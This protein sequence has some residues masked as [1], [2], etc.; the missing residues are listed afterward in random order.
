MDI[1]TS[2]RDTKELNKLVKTMLELAIED[3]KKQGV[4][5]LIVETYRPQDR[6]NYLYCQG[7][8]I[9]ECVTKGINKAFATKHCNIKVS[10]VTWTLSSI[11]KNRK[12]V[13]VV[14][15]R[16]IDG[17]M[18]AIWNAKYKETIIIINTMKKYGFEA[19]V[20]W[21]TTPDSPHFQVDGN[22][23]NVFDI[24][25][26]TKFVTIAIQT[27]LNRKINANLTVDG[28]WK[29]KTDDAV[30]KFRKAMKYKNHSGIIGAGAFK[31]LMR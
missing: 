23:T 10:K 8:T 20:D 24:S 2:S 5:P 14:P 26:N 31:E 12:A 21:K 18:T 3:I 27:A 30:I 16:K 13:D 9:D 11:H 25:H 4:N 7:R 1:T 28:I 17:K 29:A 15:Q 6:Q 22:F 19:G